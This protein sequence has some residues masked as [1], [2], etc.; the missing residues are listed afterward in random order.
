MATNLDISKCLLSE[1]QNI[2]SGKF[3]TCEQ[4]DVWI[5]IFRNRV[6]WVVMC[7]NVDMYRPFG[8]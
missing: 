5:Y 4:Y 7:P 2:L 1:K 6:V 8:L 3:I